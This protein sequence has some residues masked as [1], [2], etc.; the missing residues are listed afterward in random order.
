M[1]DTHSL[2][3]GHWVNSPP[4]PTLTTVGLFVKHN[5]HFVVWSALPLH[6]LACHSLTLWTETQKR[7]VGFHSN[8]S[9]LTH[10]QLC[11]QNGRGERRNLWIFPFFH[12]IPMVSILGRDSA[13]SCWMAIVWIWKNWFIAVSYYAEWMASW[14]QA[15]REL[16]SESIIVDILRIESNQDVFHHLGWYRYHNSMNV[17]VVFFMKNQRHSF[18]VDPL[19]AGERLFIVI[20]DMADDHR[21]IKVCA[22]HKPDPQ[23]HLGQAH[24]WMRYHQVP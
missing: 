8:C 19:G 13:P 16:E 5:E 23:L 17:G 10:I 18:D 6:S 9:S 11:I 2:I 20:H 7:F 12:Y 22:N 21:N 14:W 15:E 1:I 4:L 3:G 24:E